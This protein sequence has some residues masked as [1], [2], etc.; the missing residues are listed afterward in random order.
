MQTCQD[1][2]DQ[3]I[4]DSSFPFNTSLN[5]EYD[6]NKNLLTN[7]RFARTKTND[8]YWKNLIEDVIKEFES[9]EA[10]LAKHEKLNA[11]VY[12]NN[13]IKDSLYKELQA[14]VESPPTKSKV[15]ID[16]IQKLITE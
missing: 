13:E 12:E 4:N 15:W 7:L 6:M 9:I 10:K 2:F 5:M 8:P 1:H 3:K 16:A 14:L 11:E